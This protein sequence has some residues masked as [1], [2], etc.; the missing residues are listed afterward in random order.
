MH[1]VPKYISIFTPSDLSNITNVADSYIAVAQYAVVSL[2][3]TFSS[4]SK[5]TLVNLES[6]MLVPTTQI[7]FVALSTGVKETSY[8][9][10][11]TGRL[12]MLE[13]YFRMTILST[14]DKAASSS[15]CERTS[16]SSFAITLIL[17]FL[18]F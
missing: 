7:G 18:I 3:K 9:G 5:T 16:T 15:L 4:L 2:S 11:K 6:I 12:S 10:I 1:T 8:D 14:F 13:I 17:Y